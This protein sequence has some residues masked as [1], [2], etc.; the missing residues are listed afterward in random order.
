[1]KLK[2][3]Y[4]FI[5]SVILFIFRLVYIDMITNIGN[6]TGIIYYF[7]KYIQ[8][9]IGA[10]GRILQG[11]MYVVLGFILYNNKDKVSNIK[12]YWYIIL[13]LLFFTLNALVYSQIIRV[14]FNI[15]LV[16]LAISLPLKDNKIY[17]YLRK[18]GVIVYF[19][20]MII[21]FAYSLIVG[22]D[23]S[24]GTIAFIVCF[25]ITFIISM[26]INYINRKNNIKILN[27]IFN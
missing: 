21:F 9:I 3:S 23:D 25:S 20:H 5:I 18:T 26:I 1:M 24:K 22:F 12:Y 10:S 7:L 14:L 16:M 15:S 19:I 11:M 6:Y 4:I 8:Y 13:L 2:L 17:P 27:T